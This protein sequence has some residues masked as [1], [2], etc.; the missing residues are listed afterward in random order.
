MQRRPSIN[1]PHAEPSG[2][3]AMRAW[4]RIEIAQSPR[5][6]CAGRSQLA[7]YSSYVSGH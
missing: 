6:D 1:E 4:S 5:Q 2:G 7:L 3:T